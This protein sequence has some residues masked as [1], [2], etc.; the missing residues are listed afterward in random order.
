[1]CIKKADVLLH[2]EVWVATKADK[3]WCIGDHYY[4][5]CTAELAVCNHNATS[6]ADVCLDQKT[7]M[8]GATADP[9]KGFNVLAEKP[10]D[11][12]CF[13]TNQAEKC[14]EGTMCNPNG[15]YDATWTKGTGAKATCVPENKTIKH[16]EEA[17]TTS[18]PKR[19]I[20]LGESGATEWEEV[21]DDEEP[22]PTQCSREDGKLYPK[23]TELKKGTTRNAS[24]GTEEKVRCYSKKGTDKFFSKV[25]QIDDVCNPFGDETKDCTTTECT[26][27]HICVSKE[28]VILSNASW[29][30][31]GVTV[32]IGENAIAVDTCSEEKPYC[33]VEKGKCVYINA[34]TPAPSGGV[35]SSVGSGLAALVV[36][37][38]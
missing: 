20:C 7:M 36:A 16:G 25:C 3:K 26:E 4:K 5:V 31:T 35:K 30:K 14:G 28:A 13:D 6:A 10:Y 38:A 17:N 33:D 12:W 37:S 23:A 9:L 1:M 21:D 29:E 27:E 22:W 15:T 2:V 32:C 34:A 11:K 19:T 24:P 8:A 18:D